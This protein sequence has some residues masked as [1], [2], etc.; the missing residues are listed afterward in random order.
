[1]AKNKNNTLTSVALAFL[2]IAISVVAIVFV[3]VLHTNLQDTRKDL[4]IINTQSQHK[5]NRLTFCLDNKIVQCSDTNI[6]SWN[7]SHPENTITIKSF[8]QLTEEG[9]AEDEASRR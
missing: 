8:Q 5:I 4:L 9:I 1:M 7:T 6:E 2:S 3:S